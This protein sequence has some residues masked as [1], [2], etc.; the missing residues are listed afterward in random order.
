[1]LLAVSVDRDDGVKRIPFAKLQTADITEIKRRCQ[2]VIK[3]GEH[4]FVQHDIFVGDTV[5]VDNG[6]WSDSDFFVNR[7][8]H[9]AYGLV[10]VDAFFAEVVV[11]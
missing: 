11:L 10:G 8:H 3:L 5:R 9:A 1:M 4:F 6:H 2:V 7:G